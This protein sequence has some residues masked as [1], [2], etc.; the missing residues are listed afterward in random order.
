MLDLLIEKI[1]HFYMSKINV[2]VINTDTHGVGYYR[3]L[4]PHVYMDDEDVSI[5]IRQ[6]SDGSLN[7]GDE[8][9]VGKFQII[10]FNKNLAFPNKETSD[11]FNNII[12]KYNIKI[13]YD[14]DDYWMID[15]SHINYNQWKKNETDKII[16]NII[17]SVDYVTT[18]TP[19][20]RDKIMEINKNVVVFENAL[21]PNEYQWDYKNKIESDKIRFLWGGG[22]SHLPDLNLLKKSFTL[23]D[24]DFLSKTQLYLCGFD[25]RIRTPDGRVMK[26][27]HIGNQWVKFE[28]IF[29]N[30]WKWVKNNNY[31]KYLLEYNDENYGVV[32]EFRNE[33][34]QRRWTKP[35]LTY[36]T[37]YQEA[38]VT[39]APLNDTM[40]F[41]YYKS[42]LKVIES[43]VYKSPIIASDF[44]SYKL[45]IENGKD[46]FLVDNGKPNEWYEKMKWFTEN[47]TA[48]KE[49]GESLY[50]KVTNRYTIDIVNKKR[51][52]FYKSIVN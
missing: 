28:E 3:L 38:D 41:N 16:T 37:M 15:K 19:L 12:K 22:I 36:G 51:I 11:K 6:L 52:E 29:T 42:Q 46:G 49:M 44:G 2:L 50:E 14:I 5:T 20:F 23:F 43:G 9:F 48:I 4:N 8:R 17:K 35:I 7:L 40:M 34:Y 10:Y 25:L 26:G 1:K 24:D 45:D 13:V 33:F 21:N 39:I 30:K 31:K 32:D 27:S 18:T 47:P